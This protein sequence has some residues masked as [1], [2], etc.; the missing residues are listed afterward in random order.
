M[1]VIDRQQ[2]QIVAGFGSITRV[3]TRLHAL[4]RAGLLRRFFLGTTNGG[5]RALYA[6]SRNA[7]QL[8]DVPYAERRR[9]A[10]ETLVADFF[11]RHQ[12]AINQI[13]CALKYGP[14]PPGTSFRKWTAFGRSLTAEI[15]LIPDGYVE[16]DTSFWNFASV[17]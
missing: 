12:F 9:R 1:R 6:L 2:A 8:V 10:D 5:R 14:L 3:N 16:L 17:P 11:I 15:H 13:Y 7:A 4:T